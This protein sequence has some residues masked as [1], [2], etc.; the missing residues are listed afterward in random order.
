MVKMLFESYKDIMQM[1]NELRELQAKLVQKTKAF[2][3]VTTLLTETE[4]MEFTRLL[5]DYLKEE[6]NK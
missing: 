3:E 1:E 4:R 6:V 2:N 5:I